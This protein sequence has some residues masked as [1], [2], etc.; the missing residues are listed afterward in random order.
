LTTT[1]R[2]TAEP[3]KGEDVPLEERLLALGWERDMDSPRVG[4][5]QVEDLD[6]HRQARDDDRRVADVDLGLGA[7]RMSLGHGDER[8][9]GFELTR[10][11]GDDR[12]DRRFADLAA[13]L[14]DEPL[15]DPPRGVALLARRC[16]VVGQP[17]PDRRLVPPDR[18]SCPWRDLPGRRQRRGDG[19][20]DRPPMDL[21]AARQAADRDSQ[22]SGPLSTLGQNRSSTVLKD[23]AFRLPPCG[24]LWTANDPARSGHQSDLE[25]PAARVLLA[26]S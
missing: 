9:P 8:R 17:G 16:E 7:R 11:R 10:H 24:R 12:P 3:G 18:W 23:T 13:L 22:I 5:A 20:A 4:Q 6:L 1:T 25:V 14:I 26:P 21:V 19:L 15:P 2:I